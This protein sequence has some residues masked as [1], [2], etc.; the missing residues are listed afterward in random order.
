MWTANGIDVNQNT[1]R[2]LRFVAHTG[3][4]AAHVRKALDNTRHRIF[5]EYLVLKVNIARIPHVDESLKDLMYGHDSI[6][7]GY[8]AF[9][10]CAICQVFHVDVEEPGTCFAKRCHNISSGSHR[11]PDIDAATDAWVHVIHS[12]QYVQ[13]RRE[14]FV[15]GS[16]VVNADSNVVLLH[17]FLYVR[18]CLMRGSSDDQ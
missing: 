12:S 13:R 2:S 4:Y 6:S 3:E 14:V 5:W 18:K 16:V 17:E 10:L 1:R 8:L 7:D 9:L 15:L 11:M